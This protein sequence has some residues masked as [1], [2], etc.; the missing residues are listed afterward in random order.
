MKNFMMKN[1]IQIQNI[2]KIFIA[3]QINLP[4]LVNNAQDDFLSCGRLT[5]KTGEKR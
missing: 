3:F 2:D 1:L 4:V 5:K